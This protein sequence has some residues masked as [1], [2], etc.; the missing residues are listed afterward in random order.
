MAGQAV[1]VERLIVRGLAV[2]VLYAAIASAPLVVLL[3]GPMPEG[4]EFL[5]ELSVALAFGGIAVFMLQFVLAARFRWLKAPFGVDAV[6]HFHREIA[7]VGLALVVAHP[8]MLFFMDSGLLAL[9]NPFSAPMR[10]RYASLALLTAVLTVALS[11]FRDRLGTRYERWRLWHGVLAVVVVAAAIAHIEGVGHYVNTPVKRLLWVAYPLAWFGVLAWTRIGKP[12]RQARRPWRVAEVRP[13]A[14]DSV[15]LALEPVGHEGVHFEGGQFGWLKVGQS[16]YSLEEHP[17]SFSSSALAAPR[18]EMTIK[19]LG[20]WTEK[21]GEIAEGTVAYLDGPFGSFT[22]ERYS[23]SRYLFVAGGV[24][25]TPIVS[26]LRTRAQM[27]D[28]SSFT[29]V[30]GVRSRAD[31]TLLDELHVLAQRLDV[32]L[33]LVPARPEPDW[34][35]PSGVVTEELLGSLLPSER[36]VRAEVECFICGPPPMASAIEGHLRALGISAWRIHYERFDLV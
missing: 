27:H 2:F 7:Y 11:S 33:V 9:L 6:Y 13:E 24:G 22:L 29:L 8:L 20:D 4:R 28:P 25:I 14:G 30:Y 31:A 17:F 34:T 18:V 1:Q 19:R 16:P 23:A 26:I 21:V 12:A 15:T 5:R 32:D 35:G 3:V 10:A 36:D